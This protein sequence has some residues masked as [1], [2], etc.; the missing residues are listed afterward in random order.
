LIILNHSSFN[1]VAQT[2]ATT[3]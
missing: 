3:N 2:F 1:K